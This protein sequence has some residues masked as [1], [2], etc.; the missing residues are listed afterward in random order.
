MP[1][2]LGRCRARLEQRALK[3]PEHLCRGREDV[4]CWHRWR[5]I[6]VSPRSAYE[7]CMRWGGRRGVNAPESSS[8]RAAGRR[9]QGYSHRSDGK[10]SPGGRRRFLPG[11]LF[12]ATRR[13]QDE[14][15]LRRLP[16]ASP[17]K[18]F[19]P[20]AGGI[21]ALPL[22]SLSSWRSPTELSA[23]RTHEPLRAA[24]AERASFATM[25]PVGAHG[26]SPRRA[27]RRSPAGRGASTSPGPSAKLK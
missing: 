10:N 24:V 9:G 6:Q 16:P 17:G 15:P 20:A 1:T 21:P 3:L 23:R 25:R 4:F 18:A 11:K 7:K 19:H 22:G 8:C 26:P 5:V 14:V 12:L 2:P 13:P 27:G